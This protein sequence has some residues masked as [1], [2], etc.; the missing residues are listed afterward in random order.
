MK[1]GQPVQEAKKEFFGFRQQ[2]DDGVTLFS[3]AA[4][5]GNFPALW[6]KSYKIG[7]N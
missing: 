3:E 4:R 5:G 1:N 7:T 2:D 6:T